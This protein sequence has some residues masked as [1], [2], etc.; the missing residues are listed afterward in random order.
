M[1]R[2]RLEEI[3]YKYPGV[4][5]KALCDV[6]ISIDEGTFMLVLGASG[7]GKSSLARVIG[8]LIPD[9]YG[10]V[11]SG[12]VH[13]EE[14][15]AILFQDPEKQL[16]MNKVERELALPLENRG[17][18][19]QNMLRRV[20]EALSFM[21]LNDLKDRQ[22]SSLSGGQKQKVALASTLVGGQRI[23][24]LDEPISQLDPVNSDEI[25]EIVNR[26]N[27]DH[28]Y[29]VIL[30]EQ[31]VD[32]CIHLADRI[33]YMERGKVVFDGEPEAFVQESFKDF[34]PE[35]M[36][37]QLGS[38][39]EVFKNVKKGRKVLKAMKKTKAFNAI[40]ASIDNNRSMKTLGDFA[41]SKE[42]AIK[43]RKVKFA[44]HKERPIFDRLDLEILKGQSLAVMGANGS[45][46]TTLVK[47]ICGLLKPS[48]GDVFA[49]GGIGYVSQ[50]P[51]DHLFHDTLVEELEFTMKH[52][53]V[54]DPHLSDDVLKDLG[55]YEM[56]DRNPRDLSGGERQ[57]AAIGT[58][59]VKK[60][61]I[62]ILDEPTR[63]LDLKSKN[64]VQKIIESLHERG[65]TTIIVTHD[66]DFAASICQNGLLLFDGQVASYGDIR[67]VLQGGLYY[68][69]T[70][71]RLFRGFCDGIL[72]LE[73]GKAIFQDMVKAKASLED[74]S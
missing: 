59:L 64:R 4:N 69:T 2:I 19:E 23:L 52:S 71:N 62:L 18:S 27:R 8:N 68:T 20:S 49:N 13:V 51:N 29:T 16:I 60:P 28:G 66:I 14:E 33:L 1:G 74:I 54:V 43:V 15:T 37:L 7:S 34:L 58:V 12:K 48:R 61:D 3:N 50:N 22:L 42:V 57:R 26:L 55:L 44:Y 25:L 63:G 47:L 45:G 10:G 24:I 36:R 73:E 32:K 40:D 72:T 56:R 38:C 39:E 53:G 11:I 67:S 35:I 30:V 31:R 46:K 6:N 9:F 65:T 17:V 41:E 5:E 21:N 70:M